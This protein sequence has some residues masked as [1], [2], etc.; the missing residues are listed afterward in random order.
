MVAGVCAVGDEQA[1]SSAMHALAKQRKRP[2]RFGDIAVV[3]L[4]KNAPRLSLGVG[5]LNRPVCSVQS[6]VVKNPATRSV[7]TTSI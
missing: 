1:V 7:S 5:R 4:E 6:M 3:Y 2:M